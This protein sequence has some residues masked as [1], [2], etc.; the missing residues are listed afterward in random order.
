[1]LSGATADDALELPYAGGAGA[2]E[3]EEPVLSGATGE[4][5]EELEGEVPV[6]IGATG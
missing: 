1:M 6:E 2:E 4:E 5:A 3:P